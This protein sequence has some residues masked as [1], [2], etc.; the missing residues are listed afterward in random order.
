MRT[1][2]ISIAVVLGTASMA[3]AQAITD[4]AEIASKLKFWTQ[5]TGEPV[6]YGEVR[7]VSART[8]QVL[9]HYQCLAIAF[10]KF[11]GGAFQYA[12]KM[13]DKSK[14]GSCHYEDVT[15]KKVG[16]HGA[17]VKDSEAGFGK[18][19][20]TA[21]MSKSNI[22]FEHSIFRTIDTVNRRVGETVACIPPKGA[23]TGLFSIKIEDG[24]FRLISTRP[25]SY[26]L[27]IEPQDPQNP[28]TKPVF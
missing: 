4:P 23:L 11:E 1:A 19:V 17:C 15:S 24:R 16:N 18:A 27:N 6:Y 10:I 12:H 13:W 2:M 26:E 8:K 7:D 28:P 22:D 14:D 5:E 3:G 20:G 21:H 9:G 25:L